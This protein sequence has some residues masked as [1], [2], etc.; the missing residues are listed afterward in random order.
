MA[1]AL[2]HGEG[3]RAWRGC[4]P[5]ARVLAHGKVFRRQVAR[6]GCSATGCSPAGT[7]SRMA[8]SL[9]HS[10]VSAGA[11]PPP[12]PASSSCPTRPS[13]P[14]PFPPLENNHVGARRRRTPNAVGA[15]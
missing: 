6:R 3:A 14:L 7:C 4:T 8:G 15:P 1:K 11:L 2:A 9:A 5:M 13:F 12:T 10:T